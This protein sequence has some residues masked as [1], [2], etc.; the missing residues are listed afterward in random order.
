MNVQEPLEPVE[1]KEQVADPP[2]LRVAV[3]VTAAFAARD[4]SENVGVSS[5]VLLSVL[6]VPR[7]EVASRSGVPGAAIGVTETAEDAN[8]FPVEFLAFNLIE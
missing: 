7:S 4:E 3:N 1:V 2:P 6:L 8:E 5:E